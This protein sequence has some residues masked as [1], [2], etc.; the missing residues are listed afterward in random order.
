VGWRRT[1]PVGCCCSCFLLSCVAPRLVSLDEHPAIPGQGVAKDSVLAPLPPSLAPRSD[2]PSRPHVASAPGGS[3]ATPSFVPVFNGGPEGPQLRLLLPLAHRPP[4][5]PRWAPPIGKRSPTPV[6]PATDRLRTDTR[7]CACRR[8]LGS[9]AQDVDGHYTTVITSV[10]MGRLENRWG[11]TDRSPRLD[12]PAARCV[13][14]TAPPSP[15]MMLGP[16]LGPFHAGQLLSGH[17]GSWVRPNIRSRCGTGTDSKRSDPPPPRA[18]PTGPPA[19]RPSHTDA[20]HPTSDTV[21]P[22]RAP[23]SR[24]RRVGCGSEEDDAV[25]FV[26]IGHRTRGRRW[27]TC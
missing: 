24:L 10:S 8:L 15:D 21:C 14:S 19:D 11:P 1:V 25:D 9:D 16:P 27:K 18:E 22:T 6:R 7:S 2:N 12:R 17:A 3:V 5:G 26:G 13:S 20:L 4:S 23:A